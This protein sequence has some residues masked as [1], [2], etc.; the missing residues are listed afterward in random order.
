MTTVAR[1][2]L[3][4][5]V[6]LAACSHD[7]PITRWVELGPDGMIVRAIVDGS[8][9]CPTLR[10]HGVDQQMTLRLGPDSDFPV[11]VCEC[12][13]P[14]DAGEVTV[15]GEP[16]PPVTLTP[17]RIALFA[18][19]GCRL[20]QGHPLQACNDPAAWPLA[21]I[22]A[23]IAAYGPDLILHDGDLIYR[24]MACPADAGVDC[25]G[26][27]YGDV[28]PTWQADV[29]D[30]MASL[31]PAAPWVFMR[32]CHETCDRNG[33]GWFRFID[34]RPAPPSG[35]EDYT[36]P[37]ALPTTPQ[38]LV[39]DSA[40][41]VDEAPPPSVVDVYRAQLTALEGLANP[42][43]W[44]ATHKPVW[45]F[46]QSD[47]TLHLIDQTLQLAIGPALVAKVERFL[48]GHIHLFEVIGFAGGRPPE[49]VSGTGGT[50]L[51]DPI[52]QP[53]VGIDAGGAT[54]DFATVLSRFG[55]STLEFSPNAGWVLTMRDVDGNA[56]VDCTVQ[57][58]E[59]HCGP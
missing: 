41:A 45:G 40:N 52:T 34:P 2:A 30:P 11:G 25:Q 15:A 29:F 21:Q 44:L 5:F 47:D 49:F 37:Y 51:D 50:E 59:V 33:V 16:L 20:K 7:Q 43:A 46:R 26:S 9:L 55:F 39:L 19:T 18:D 53:L 35:C 3:V 4:G 1:V 23:S 6:F 12:T 8:S 57:G 13:L 17:Q 28:W 27:P 10:V 24:E 56:L 14:F 58:T 38:L 48:F 22:A 36:D 32:G 31:L 42:G 54:V